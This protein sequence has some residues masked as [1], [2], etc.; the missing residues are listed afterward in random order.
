M[1]N[2]Q[3]RLEAM[4]AWSSAKLYATTKRFLT[5]VPQPF[6]PD[7]S[8]RLPRGP[9]T[10]LSNEPHRSWI[11]EMRFRAPYIAIDADGRVGV[12]TMQAYINAWNEAN[13][14]MGET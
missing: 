8:Y 3:A 2:A 6:V 4:K 12:D 7:L 1:N 11:F 14:L 13:Y 5:P 10:V 9:R